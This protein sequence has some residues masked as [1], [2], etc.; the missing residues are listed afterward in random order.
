VAKEYIRGAGIHASGTIALANKT[1][2]WR[3]VD[4]VVDHVLCIGCKICS[5]FCPDDCIERLEVAKS[6]PPGTPRIVIDMEYCKGCG[7]CAHEC[8]KLAITMVKIEA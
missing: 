3:L 6:A 7:I 8:P 4:P 5:Q 2:N 1:G